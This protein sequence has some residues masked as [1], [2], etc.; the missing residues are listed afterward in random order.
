MNLSKLK[1]L[2]GEKVNDIIHVHWLFL[3]VLYNWNITYS[4]KGLNRR[5]VDFLIRFVVC[6][7][8]QQYKKEDLN[9][10]TVVK[11]ITVFDTFLYY[12]NVKKKT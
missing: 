3:I 6:S 2:S 4:G 10:Q 5:N 11:K 12:F 1:C 8:T 7:N 9:L